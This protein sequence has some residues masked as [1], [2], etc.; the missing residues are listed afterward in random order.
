MEIIVGENRKLL[1][2]IAMVLAG[3]AVSAQRS[4]DA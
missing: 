1:G 3:L 2:K 4:S